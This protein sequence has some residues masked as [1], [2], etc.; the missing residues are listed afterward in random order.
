MTGRGKR[1]VSATRL[2]RIPVYRHGTAYCAMEKEPAAFIENAANAIGCGDHRRLYEMTRRDLVTPCV[3]IRAG[4][5]RRY[6]SLPG[7]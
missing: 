2:W 7:A 4:N 1:V 3:Q 6:A 5:S